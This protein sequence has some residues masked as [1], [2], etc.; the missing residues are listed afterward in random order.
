MSYISLPPPEAFDFTRP[1]RWPL[2]IKRYGYY[3]D[4]IELDKRDAATQISALLRHMGEESDDVKSKLDLTPAEANDY[5]A[6]VA[7]FTAYFDK[8]SDYLLERYHFHNRRQN[9]DERV[10]TFFIALNSLSLTC[11]YDESVRR[12]LVR[13]RL[14][15][16]LRDTEI[17]VELLSTPDLTLDEATDIARR[18]ERA[19]EMAEEM[20]RKPG[21]RHG[22]STTAPTRGGRRPSKWV[23][24]P[25]GQPSCARC[26]YQLYHNNRGS[27]ICPAANVRCDKCDKIGHYG[28]VCKKETVSKKAVAAE[29]RL[30][31]I[32]C[33]VGNPI[34][35]S[36]W[37][38][39]L[40]VNGIPVV[41]KI[42]TGA[43]VTVVPET[44]Y[45]DVLGGEP[46]LDAAG[47]RLRGPGGDGDELTVVGKFV[48]GLETGNGMTSREEIY[49]A[50]G[51]HEALLGR[52]AIRALRL[53]AVPA[54]SSFEKVSVTQ[55]LVLFK[56]LALHNRA[57][58][59]QW[60]P[61]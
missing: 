41:F 44:V 61:L 8:T 32:V 40:R 11:K 60:S 7:K 39:S 27:T 49:V 9:A 47:I 50:S 35:A 53:I 51:L 36:P 5:D 59:R 31:E 33:V 34:L 25:P 14:I 29:G 4:A 42:D 56:A 15:V 48:V 54:T 21:R 26:G 10:F 30:D 1:P 2:W 43:D 6:I 57:Y 24:P 3:R 37:T 45:A 22:K 58:S 20:S 13:D 46:A 23:P 16:G 38:V 12:E 52:P 28:R 17:V 55:S 19:A 18:M